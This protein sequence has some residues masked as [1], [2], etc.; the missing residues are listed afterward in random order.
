MIGS[1]PYLGATAS[2][3]QSVVSEQHPSRRNQ[4]QNEGTSTREARDAAI[5]RIPF[6]QLTPEAGAQ[7][8]T[9]VS[10]AS[11]FRGMPTETVD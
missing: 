6:Q 1:V 2:A 9:V 3:Q 11:Y 8:R 7:L 5:Q 10:N 4:S